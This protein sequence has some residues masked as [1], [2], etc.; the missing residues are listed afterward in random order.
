MEGYN[1]VSDGRP[2]CIQLFSANAPKKRGID[3]RKSPL[4]AL[5][6]TGRSKKNTNN[7]CDSGQ[8]LSVCYSLRRCTA[9]AVD[10]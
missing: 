1:N 5:K 9:D 7:A 4:H 6:R 3:Y 10:Q 8:Y 2:V